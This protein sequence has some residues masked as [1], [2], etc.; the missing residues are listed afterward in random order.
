LCLS[1]Y[2]R[3]H[4]QPTASKRNPGSR[5]ARTWTESGTEGRREMAR[6]AA[7]PEAGTAGSAGK[8][9]AAHRR[10]ERAPRRSGEPGSREREKSRERRRNEC[11]ERTRL[12]KETTTLAG[13]EYP[14]PCVPSANGNGYPQPDTRRHGGSSETET[15]ARCKK[16]SDGCARLNVWLSCCSWCLWCWRYL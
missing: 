6:Q 10:G 11:N 16:S 12:L 9:T 1:R 8:R 5:R 13:N 2:V 7:G 4:A 15:R 14:G 3:N